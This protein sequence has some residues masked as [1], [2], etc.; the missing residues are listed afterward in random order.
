MQL[1]HKGARQNKQSH[2]N[3][4]KPDTGGEVT[5]WGGLNATT[6]ST[7]ISQERQTRCG[8]KRDL[9]FLVE[10]HSMVEYIACLYGHPTKKKKICVLNNGVYII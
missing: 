9:R 6:Y 2:S 4:R 7:V 1:N 5:F 8:R 10:M 3:S